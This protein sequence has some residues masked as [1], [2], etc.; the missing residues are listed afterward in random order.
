MQDRFEQK[1]HAVREEVRAMN[2]FVT[3]ASAH[4]GENKAKSVVK[5]TGGRSGGWLYELLDDL[6]SGVGARLRGQDRKQSRVI[7]PRGLR[8]WCG[9]GRG[10]IRRRR[11]SL[12]L[13]ERDV[14]VW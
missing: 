9:T 3:A 8:S 13:V 2:G 1:L 6:G 11:S 14:P 10:W 12:K 4:R 7:R 5:S